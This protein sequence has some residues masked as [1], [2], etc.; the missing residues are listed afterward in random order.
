MLIW[1]SSQD[2]NDNK[3]IQKIYLQQVTYNIHCIIN[4]LIAIIR[5]PTLAHGVQKIFYRKRQISSRE[6]PSI[7]TTIEDTNSNSP[8][9]SQWVFS[10]QL[11]VR[12]DR[13]P[14]PYMTPTQSLEIMYQGSNESNGQYV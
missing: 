13:P 11:V 8:Y 14:P 3:N 4:P 9:F 1:D 6:Y 7:L 10:E 2:F 12:L 5:D